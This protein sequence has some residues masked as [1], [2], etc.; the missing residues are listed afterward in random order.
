MVNDPYVIQ[1]YFPKS[2]KYPYN[3]IGLWRNICKQLFTLGT[4]AHT[5]RHVDEVMLHLSVKSC[6]YIF[7]ER[8]FVS[9]WDDCRWFLAGW[10]QPHNIHSPLYV[11]L[12]KPMRLAENCIYLEHIRIREGVSRW[13]YYMILTQSAILKNIGVGTKY[14]LEYVITISKRLLH[15]R[16]QEYYWYYKGFEWVVLYLCHRH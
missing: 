15:S 2:K 1:T 13:R 14:M 9:A 5:Y 11:L 6:M 10:R 4:S 3:H 8:L 12:L 7:R 16:D